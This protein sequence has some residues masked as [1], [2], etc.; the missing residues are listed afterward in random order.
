MFNGPA[1]TTKGG[2]AVDPMLA[3]L[4]LTA[5]LVAPAARRLDRRRL[6]GKR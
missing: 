3:V 6:G 4:A 2:G 5:A 1:H